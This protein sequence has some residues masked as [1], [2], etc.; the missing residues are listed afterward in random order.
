MLETN[1]NE[2]DNDY[3]TLQS[4]MLLHGYTHEYKKNIEKLAELGQKNAIQQWLLFKGINEHNEI[5]K[6]HIDRQSPKQNL[7]DAW[8]AACALHRDFAYIE[9]LFEENEKLTKEIFSSNALH[10]INLNNKFIEG[11]QFYKYRNIALSLCLQE[12]N[13]T[14]N[15]LYLQKYIDMQIK[16]R[17]DSYDF[18]KDLKRIRKILIKK[19][20]KDIDNTP[21]AFALAKSITYNDTNVNIITKSLGKLILQKLANRQLSNKFLSYKKSKVQEQDKVENTKSTFENDNEQI[22]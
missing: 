19:Y 13:S 16:F 8:T 14:N 15:I 5:I 12:Y 2:L 10:Q 6:K 3:V 9:N 18:K 4:N 11:S 21:V 22:L 20:K 17:L 7:D 1:F